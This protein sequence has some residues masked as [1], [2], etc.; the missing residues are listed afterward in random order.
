MGCRQPS[1]TGKVT[2]SRGLN[3]R[4]RLGELAQTLGQRKH[5]NV[6]TGLWAVVGDGSEAGLQWCGCESENALFSCTQTD[7]FVQLRGTLVTL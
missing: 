4:E 2:A 5:F 7:P 1:V 3:W 6:F